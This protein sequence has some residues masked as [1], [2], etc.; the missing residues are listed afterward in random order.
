MAGHMRSAAVC[1]GE[2]GSRGRRGLL[3][4]C[5]LVAFGAGECREA[6]EELA[7]QRAGHSYLHR[8]RGYIVGCRQR[9]EV[10]VYDGL[11]P[12][13][14]DA[15]VDP[16]EELRWSS[17]QEALWRVRWLVAKADSMGQKVKQ[18]PTALDLGD[19]WLLM[20]SRKV[21]DRR[22]YFNTKRGP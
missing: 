19:G 21:P 18:R 22:F 17:Y 15:A 6:A 3:F 10:D 14:P 2:G 11:L 13:E 20:Q 7:T 1:D 16:P 8:S 12:Y 9:C 4:F 5:F